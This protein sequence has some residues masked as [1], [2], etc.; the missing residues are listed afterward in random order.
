MNSPIRHAYVHVPFCR[1]RCGYCDFTLV[2]GRDDLFE[3]YFTALGIEL[4]RLHQPAQL[5]TLYLG[6]GTPTHVGPNGVRRLFS[7]F[8]DTLK[9]SAAAEV[10]IEANPL[11]ITES[12]IEA[13][14]ACGINRVSLGVQSLNSTTLETLDRD[15]REG[16]VRQV[17]SLLGKS[18][19][20]VSVDLIIAVPEQ[21]LDLVARDVEDIVSLSPH[22]VSVYCLTWETGTAFWGK[23][24]R[25]V[26]TPVGEDLEREMYEL[27]IDRLAVAGYQQ[28][29]V[30]NFAQPAMTCRHNEAYWDCRAWEAFGPGAARFDGLKRTTNVRS[31]SSWIGKLLNGQNVTGHVDTMTSEEAARERLVLGLRR[32]CGVERRAFFQA[33]GFDVDDLAQKPIQKWIAAGFAV[34]DGCRIRLTRS[35]MLVSDS[36]WPAVL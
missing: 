9:Y 35:G 27:V 1:H 3:N 16:D 11:D 23:R 10:T 12:M 25:G 18:G 8:H 30:S 31:V 4:K 21:T 32:R 14:Y 29:E 5:E 7:E 28:Y 13:F 15:H 6:G 34:D 20:T 33:S 26:L 22:H 17:M 19:L 24:Q 36:L 2:A